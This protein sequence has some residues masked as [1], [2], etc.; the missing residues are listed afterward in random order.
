[1]EHGT[2]RRSSKAPNNSFFE[3]WTSEQDS[4]TW[5]VDVLQSGTYEA[6]VYYTCAKPNV[7]ISVNLTWETTAGRSTTSAKVIEAFD[8]PLYDKS[9]ERV[10]K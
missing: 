3:H 6:L 1:V 2:I 5:D 8:P 4:I 10:E 7:G 9:K